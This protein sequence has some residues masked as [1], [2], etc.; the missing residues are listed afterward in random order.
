MPRL[1][2]IEPV[3]TR[4]NPSTNGLV[5]IVPRLASQ[6]WEIEVQGHALDPALA[7]VVT[8]RQMP[9]LHLPFG[10]A[11]WFYFFLYHWLALWERLTGKSRPDVVVSTGFL[12]LPADIATV[13]FSHVNWWFAQRRK[14]FRTTEAWLHLILSIP[15]FVTELLLL[16]SPFKTL[17]LAVSESV[18]EDMRRYAA[19]WKRVKVLPNLAVF[20]RFNPGYRAQTREDAR[21]QHNFT[22]EEQV[23]VFSSMGH[24]Y[25]KGFADTVHIVQGLRKRGHS[26]RLLVVG[27]WPSSLGRQC[28]KFRKQIPDYEDWIVF[29]GMVDNPEYHLSAADGL[30]F[31]SL[32]EAFSLVEIEASMLGLPLF[33]TAHHGSEMILQCGVNG[34]LLPWDVDEM[35][36]VMEEEILEGKVKPRDASIGKAMSVHDYTEGW[37]AVL[38]ETF[39]KPGTASAKPKLALIGHTYMVRVNREKA[40][41]LASHFEVRVY[42]CDTKGWKVMGSEV[43]DSTDPAEASSLF[44]LDRWPRSQN[45]TCLL[46]RG[47]GREL[48]WFQPDV[49]LVENEPWSWLRWQTRVAAWVHAPR[50]RFAEFTWENVKRPGWRGAILSVVYRLTAMTSGKVICGNQAAKDLFLKAG[51]RPENLR[52]DGQLGVDPL[53]HPVATP[54]ERALWRNN[55]GWGKD[56]WVIGFCGRFVEEKGL[57]EL[58]EACRRVRRSMPDLRLAL[59]GAGPLHE[60]LRT[61]GETEWLQLLP[62]VPHRQIPE[63]LNKIDLFV[64]P[65]KPMAKPNGEVWEEQ[66]GHVLIEAMACGT[67]TVGSN[68]GAI[69]EILDDPE[70]T[71]CHSD[72]ESLADTITHWLSDDDARRRKTSKQRDRCLAKWSHEALAHRYAEFLDA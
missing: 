41:A 67:L 51:T 64:L 68:S 34:R 66:F 11:V 28:R 19:P 21:R 23:F 29:T 9:H 43:Q 53:A 13:H 24:H 30:L 18:A 20:D 4:A 10:Q 25:R 33:L 16:W 40:R 54:E 69:P 62:A 65:S 3:F 56:D 6:G 55:L 70:V 39:E 48:A 42:T 26:A 36:Q 52:V 14:G 63:F 7:G 47:L 27:G 17:L 2:F 5:Q 32:S 72:V 46:F 60:T 49:V 37:N 12:Y 15:G 38:T 57:A 1:R 61:A 35:I 8:H 50:A 22:P 58:V 44:R 31:P 71:F 45:Y 59:L